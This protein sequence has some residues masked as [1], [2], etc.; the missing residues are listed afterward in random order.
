M[1]VNFLSSEDEMK[2]QQARAE[3]QNKFQALGRPTPIPFA[4]EKE[5]DFRVRALSNL[6]P[7]VPGFEDLK[8]DRYLREP[9]FKYVEKQIFEAADK[10]ARQPTNIPEGQLREVKKLDES[11]RPTYE[12]YGKPSSWM[13]D[14]TTGTKKRLVSIRTET[15]RG[16]VP[17]NMMNNLR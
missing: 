11:G 6:Q 2:L 8:I 16:Y 4:D 7:L 17:G 9:N 15:Q 3:Y 10:E 13:R 1:P 5:P 12:F 14:F